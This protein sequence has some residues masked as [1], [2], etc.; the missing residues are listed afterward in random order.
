[1]ATMTPGEF[2]EIFPEFSDVEKF[3]DARV[4]YWLSLGEMMI[5]RSRWGALYRHGIALYAAHNLSLEYAIQKEKSYGKGGGG[6]VTGG[7]KTV[8]S[9]SKTESYSTMAY[10]GAGN[11]AETEFGRQLWDLIK[12]FGAGGMQVNNS[13]QTRQYR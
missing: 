9:V 1:M 4:E 2:R 13:C 11:Y 10:E 7:S 5:V 8:G 12:Q 6:P 3:S